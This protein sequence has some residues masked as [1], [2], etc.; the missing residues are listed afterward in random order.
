MQEDG[1]R[2][3]I[4]AA[5][6]ANL[7]IAGAKFAAFL[8][9]GAASMLAEAVHSLAD[10]GNQGLLILGTARAKREATREHPFGYGRERY[11]W[12]FV[13]AMVLFVLGSI[14]AIY[15]GVEK[16][17]HPHELASPAIA[18]GVLVVAIALESWSFR[19]AIVAAQPLR[20]SKNWW[21]FIRRSK[22]P[23]LPV[24]LLEDLGALLGLVFALIG[25]SLAAALGEPRF[26]AIGSIAIGALLG[27][28]AV[29][30]SIEMKSLLI[31]ESAQAEVRDAIRSAIEASP[32]VRELIHMRT[33]HLGPD[34]LLVAVK[35]DFDAGLD[36]RGLASAIDELESAIR[37][38]APIARVIY[39]EPDIARSAS[40]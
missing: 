16:L 22:S 7:G 40:A 13:V 14:F 20:G 25:V 4:V 1:S 30:L 33:L 5:F 38:R 24:V 18:I 31:G 3:A 27:V 6:L 10:T 32:S 8:V 36:L 17:R 28:I 29:V 34:E 15:E 11:F 9:T 23:E 12:A 21:S 26:D 37:N 2:R 19:T 39:V 35:V